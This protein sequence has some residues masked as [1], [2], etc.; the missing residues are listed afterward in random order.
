M[1]Q[2][3]GIALGTRLTHLA[4][5]PIASLPAFP[6][7]QAN[8]VSEGEHAWMA[9]IGHDTRGQNNP[10]RWLGTYL[11]LMHSGA[12]IRVTQTNDETRVFEIK[13]KAQ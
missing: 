13:R 2:N 9:W 7:V 1:F 10:H 4:Y 5:V 11:L 3:V 12:V 6:E 8:C